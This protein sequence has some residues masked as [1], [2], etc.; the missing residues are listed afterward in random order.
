M[1]TLIAL[2][3]RSTVAAIKETDHRMINRPGLGVDQ[4]LELAGDEVALSNQRH[5][6]NHLISVC[7]LCLSGV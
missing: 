5:Q 4:A 3:T 7:V 6:R 2:I 1:I